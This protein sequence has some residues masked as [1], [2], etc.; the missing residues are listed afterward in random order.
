MLSSGPPARSPAPAALSALEPQVLARLAERAGIDAGTT[1]DLLAFLPGLLQRPE[2]VALTRGLVADLLSMPRPEAMAKVASSGVDRLLGEDVSL[3]YLLLALLEIPA[4]VSRH[5]SLQVDATISSDTLRDLSIW[6]R[7]FRE[8]FGHKGITLE[9]LDWAQYYLRGDLYRIGA[10][11]LEMVRFSGPIRAFRHKTTQELR[12]LAEPGHTFFH[13][14]RA[15]SKPLPEGGRTA[16][17]G[18]EPDAFVAEGS[19]DG[20][21]V[22]GHLVGPTGAVS[23]EMTSLD[24]SEHEI[25]LWPGAPMLEMHI[26]E[27]ARVLVTTFH[28]SLSAALPFF[29]RLFPEVS[30]LGIFGE[31]WLLDPQVPKL[32]P[33]LSG[34]AAIQ[35]ICTLYPATIP[36][37][38]TIRRLFGP[39]ATRRSAV[40]APREGMN[41]LQRSIASFLDAPENNLCATGGFLLNDRIAAFGISVPSASKG[42]SF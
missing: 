1:G 4:A 26:P 38:K 30:P 15:A 37:A 17:L 8:K 3:Y 31:A 9:I 25:A 23:R 10:L 34:I 12:V 21:K 42:R 35:S 18:N 22:T 20:P 36:E 24:T 13:G 40:S 28:S 11:Q 16:Q 19:M 41:I 2:M 7:H 29:G 14:G 39:T 27:G 5:E 32:V 33:K 6:C